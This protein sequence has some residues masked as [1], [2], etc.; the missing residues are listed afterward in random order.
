VRLDQN[1]FVATTWV[2]LPGWPAVDFRRPRVE[3]PAVWPPG[4]RLQS[5]FCTWLI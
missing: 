3:P 4:A 2:E 5:L 1:E